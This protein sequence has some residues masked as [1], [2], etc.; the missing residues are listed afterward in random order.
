M[1]ALEP[2]GT[3]VWVNRAWRR[4]AEALGLKDALT[5]VS[6]FGGISSELRGYFEAAFAEALDRREPFD[7]E[8]QCPTPEE[9]RTFLLRALPIEGAGLLVEHSLVVRAPAEPS[10]DPVPARY[11]NSHGLVTQCSNCRRVRHPASGAWH[12]VADWVRHTQTF[13]SHGL[14]TSCAGFFWGR[15]I[16]GAK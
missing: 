7:L 3:I 2:S 12:W 14:C 16:R 13:I 9:Q 10:E 1:A 5:E 4:R 15:R 8:Y 11:Q 6:Y